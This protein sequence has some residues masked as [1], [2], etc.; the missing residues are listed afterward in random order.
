MTEIREVLRV[1]LSG[2]GCAGW[3][4]RLEAPMRGDDKVRE[5]NIG[6]VWP[7]DGATVW[8]DYVWDTRPR[9]KRADRRT[10]LTTIA[11]ADYR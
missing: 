11:G 3:P 8:V 7:S 4:G 1:W 6:I 5:R 9:G 2:S 10:A